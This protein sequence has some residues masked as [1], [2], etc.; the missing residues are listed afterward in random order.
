MDAR[1]VESQAIATDPISRDGDST[2]LLKRRQ[3]LRGEFRVLLQRFLPYESKSKPDQEVIILDVGCSNCIEA[4]PLLEHFSGEHGA[5]LYGIDNS[6]DA[7]ESAKAIHKSRGESNRRG[8][9]V[10][11]QADATKNDCLQCVPELADIVVIRRHELGLNRAVWT[12]MITNTVLKLAPGGQGI[13][14]SR[15]NED[16]RML[17]ELLSLLP[18]KIVKDETNE[19]QNY[20]S[21]HRVSPDA[22]VTVIQKN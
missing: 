1:S 6:E 15:T 2:D 5:K 4:V 11:L 10:F 22:F 12:A 20:K 17:L 19:Y 9:A 3:E 18:C 8:T 13:F 7:I 21:G 14:T 16:H